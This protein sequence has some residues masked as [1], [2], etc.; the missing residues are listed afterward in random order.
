[1]VNRF[2]I[3]YVPDRIPYVSGL[4][5]KCL[6]EMWTNIPEDDRRGMVIAC[7]DGRHCETCRRFIREHGGD[8]RDHQG[9]PAE[10]IPE[11]REETDQWWRD[12]DLVRC[13]GVGGGPFD[14]DPMPDEDTDDEETRRA[15]WAQ[16][17]Y[18]AAFVCGPCPVAVECRR[19]ARVHGYEGMWGGRY[20][21]RLSWLDPL[22]GDRGPTLHTKPRERDRLMTRLLAKGYDVD[23]EKIEAEVVA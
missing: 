22:T 10:R 16:R 9:S 23:E 11:E 13:F 21:A 1:V 7:G 6:R 18:I 19:A 8:P 5:V 20:Y 15:L 4:C 14:P 12:P 17:R 3:T 2:H